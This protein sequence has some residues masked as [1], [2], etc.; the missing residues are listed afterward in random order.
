M[1]TLAGGLSSHA[2]E[3]IHLS[4]IATRAPQDLLTASDGM[5]RVDVIWVV[6]SATIVPVSGQS[7]HLQPGRPMLAF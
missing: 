4:L 7:R 1:H 2:V 6:F 3:L 5:L